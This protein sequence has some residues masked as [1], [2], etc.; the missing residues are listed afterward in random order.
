M[1]G[2]RAQRRI[3]RERI[4]HRAI[5]R[6]QIALAVA[7]V[8]LVPLFLVI[9]R[10]RGGST[11][12]A[13]RRELAP[14]DARST[15]PST[16]PTVPSTTIGRASRVSITKE[17]ARPG[18]EAWR[19]TGSPDAV[20][21][22]ADRTSVP[23]GGSFTLRVSTAAPTFT[24]EAYRMGY[25][26]GRLG[27][28]VWTSP[29]TPGAVQAAAQVAPTTRM[30]TAGWNPSLTVSTAGWP[31][32]TYLLKLVVPTGQSY[33][34]ITVRDDAGRSDLLVVDAVTT[35]QAYNSWGSHNL[36]DGPRADPELRST[37]VSFD[38]PYAGSG[39]DEFVPNELGVVATAERL[40]LDVSY[41]TDIDVHEQPDLLRTHRAIT[42]L[43]HD[44]YWSLEMRNG[45]EAARDAGTNLVFFGANSAYRRIR[46]E[47]SALGPDRIVV[48]YRSAAADP[49][50][51]TDP[52]R[53]TTSWREPPSARP[54]S[55]LTGVFYE[56]NPVAAPGV[57]A[58]PTAWM[59]EGTGLTKGAQIPGLVGSEYDR[60]NRY[61]TTPSPIQAVLH[62][63]VTCKGR[64]SYSDAA[65]Y[66]AASGAGVFATGTNAWICHLVIGC[67]KVDD[68]IV[69]ITENL[70]RDFVQGPAARRHPAVD[71]TA[72][73]GIKP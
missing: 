18:T 28:L 6:R 20:R 13:A 39:A 46:L 41:A 40:G 55:A 61:W 27:R 37:K 60:I 16:A 21:G 69:R 47:S 50:A 23:S 48:N 36:Y 58:D 53:A 5:V 34:P 52:Q 66:T 56:C 43:G 68:S 49:L 15:A 17:N 33:V 12:E 35:W 45:V 63:P 26:G 73:V 22:Y 32:G 11:P 38:R 8:V 42:F 44:E 59:L 57:V 54:E 9:D 19:L 10:H 14:G 1:P 3:E 62:S 67:P 25:Y 24:V 72:A 30:V 31:H 29:T 64:A 70:L 7:I 4:R 51:R 71:N 2:G 65:Y